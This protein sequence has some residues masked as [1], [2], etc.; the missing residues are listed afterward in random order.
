MSPSWFYAVETRVLRDFGKPFD[1]DAAGPAPSK[2]AAIK[3]FVDDSMRRGDGLLFN[4][5]VENFVR[6]FTAKEGT[7]VRLI[8][9]GPGSEG[10]CTQGDSQVICRIGRESGMGD[11]LFRD[12]SRVIPVPD[13]QR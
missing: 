6:E 13:P 8:D 9:G 11:W 12:I 4:P 2:R 5:H 3:F 10:S 1:G 7:A